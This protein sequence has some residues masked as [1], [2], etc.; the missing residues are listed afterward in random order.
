MKDMGTAKLSCWEGKTDSF[1]QEEKRTPTTKNYIVES[2][3]NATE[4]EMGTTAESLELQF[5]L[6]L[7]LYLLINV[8][9]CSY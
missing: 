2:G 7:Y 1:V 4:I 8:K 9:S 5:Q 6:Y 3:L